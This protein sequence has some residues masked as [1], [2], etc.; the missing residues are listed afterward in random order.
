MLSENGHIARR[1]FLKAIA[2]LGLSSCTPFY[3]RTRF[4][5]LLTNDP[6]PD[7]YNPILDAL[8]DL[9]LPFGHPNFPSITPLSV[10]NNIKRHF[11]LTEERQE[12]LQRAFIIFN[13]IQLFPNKLP[14]LVDQ[15]VMLFEEFEELNTAD[16]E[17]KINEFLELDQHLFEQ[18][19]TKF[20]THGTF[21]KAPKSVR[22][23]YF[24]LWGQSSFSI[25]RMFYNSTKGLINACAYNQKEM[26]DAIGY[27]GHFNAK[28]LR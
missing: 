19:E 27:E 9:I 8:I 11:P 16:I 5:H 13:D 20:G 25:R 7:H 24:S 28:G 10:R 15:E 23:A 18:F 6:H 3:P 12:P 14:A 2:V 26:W 4:I 17:P 21:L 22:A 1:N